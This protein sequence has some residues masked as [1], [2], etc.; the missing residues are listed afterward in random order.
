MPFDPKQAKLAA[1]CE[2]PGTLYGLCYDPQ[3]GRL[4]GAGTDWAVYAVDVK[5]EKPAAEKL[6]TQH[7]NYVSALVW[8]EGV[9]ISAGYDRK[10]IWT[11]AATG[12]QIRAI[13]AHA[14]WV[15]NLAL[16]PDGKRLAS[17]GDDLLVKLWDAR[18]GELLHICD[19][20]A[21][22]TPQGFATAIYALAVSPDGKVVASGDRIGEVCLWEAESGTLVTR[23]KAPAFYTYDAVKRSRSLGG[24]RGLGFSPDGKQLAISG[25]GAVSNVDGFVGPCRVEV[26]DWPAGQ[27]S[28][29]G[30]DQ[31]KGILNHIAFHPSEPWLL[32]AGGG[33]SGGVLSFWDRKSAE[34]THKV[35]PKGHAQ[36]FCLDPSGT[37]LFAAGAGGFQIWDLE[38]T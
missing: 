37:K 26:W 11:N 17:I 20:H 2:H 16:C 36:R 15:R 19:G 23:I 3:A 10:L 14:G 34:P 29:A 30:Q 33:D 1:S 21:K 22:Q 4:Y 28:Y 38:G 24:I 18:T 32:A 12:E 5:A 25:I 9:L 31:H 7:E 13:E 8:L 27:R 35:Q 6:W